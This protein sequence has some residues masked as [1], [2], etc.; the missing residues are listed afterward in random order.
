MMG[1]RIEDTH[2]FMETIL[3]QA[4]FVIVNQREDIKDVILFL[5]SLFA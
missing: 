5:L 1:L 3:V 2:L 4:N